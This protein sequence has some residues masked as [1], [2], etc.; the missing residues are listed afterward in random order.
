MRHTEDQPSSVTTPFLHIPCTSLD[1]KAHK[2]GTRVSILSSDFS[3][4]H[5][6]CTHTPHTHHTHTPHTDGLLRFAL[7]FP[8]HRVRVR[9]AR[10]F[11]PSRRRRRQ[12]RRLR[13]RL[14]GQPFSHG[15]VGRSPWVYFVRPDV[16]LPRL[17]ELRYVSPHPVSTNKAPFSNPCAMQFI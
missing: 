17:D 6:V 13:S 8:L 15:W 12:R 4:Q 10:L 3:S 14:G 2:R 16:N 7:H 11:D 1:P 9:A 5:L